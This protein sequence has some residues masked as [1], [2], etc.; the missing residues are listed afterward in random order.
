MLCKWKDDLRNNVGKSSL[1]LKWGTIAVLTW[2]DYRQ[3]QKIGIT[4]VLTEI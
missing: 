3:Q 4:G 1:G 2:S